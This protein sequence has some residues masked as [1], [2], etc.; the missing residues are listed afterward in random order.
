MLSLSRRGGETSGRMQR[1]L[2][3]VRRDAS[4]IP[5]LITRSQ[6]RGACERW[7]PEIER[8]V[9]AE[10]PGLITRVPT[11][12]RGVGLDG[13]RR[14][15]RSRTRVQSLRER[16]NAL[17]YLRSALQAVGALVVGQRLRV[18][19]LS[20]AYMRHG[21]PRASVRLV[22]VDRLLEMDLRSRDIPIFFIDPSQLDARIR[23]I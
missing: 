6:P 19:L 3:A 9:L 15:A 5:E 13:A 22:Q 20:L 11:A 4:L 8:S 2:T 14:G 16:R 17:G 18:V 23:Q 21:A 12:R 1:G 10:Q 7:I